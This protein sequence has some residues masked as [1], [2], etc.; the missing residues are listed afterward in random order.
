MIDGAIL[1]S[2]NDLHRDW[3]PK[4]NECNLILKHKKLWSPVAATMKTFSTPQLLLQ[5]NLFSVFSH[6]ASLRCLLHVNQ[7]KAHSIL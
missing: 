4:E 1:Q 5:L 6:W 2:R 7:G 3:N